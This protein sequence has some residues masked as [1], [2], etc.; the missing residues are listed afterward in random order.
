MNKRV[1]NVILTSEM[2]NA[3]TNALTNG[4][5]VG[6]ISAKN[7]YRLFVGTT[8]PSCVNCKNFIPGMVSEGYCKLYGNILEA[9]TIGKCG[10]DAID[11]VNRK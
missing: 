1:L 4:M 7:L 8:I 2:N 11:F 5:T 10:V 6:M 9:R 3:L